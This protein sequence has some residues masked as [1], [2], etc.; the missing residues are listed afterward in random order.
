MRAIR[1]WKYS[2]TFFLVLTVVN[3]CTFIAQSGTSSALSGE[4]TDPSGDAVPRAAITLTD[5]NTRATRIS[6]SAAEPSTCGSRNAY[7][8]SHELSPRSTA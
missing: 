6:D 8:K 7:Q 3:P 5:T 4:V 2:F 1:A